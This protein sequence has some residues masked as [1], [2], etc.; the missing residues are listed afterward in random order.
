[1][2]RLHMF[3]DD[4]TYHG[5]KQDVTVQWK[6][7]CFPENITDVLETCDEKGDD[8]VSEYEFTDDKIRNTTDSER[9]V[10]L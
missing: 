7:N 9:W 10:V 1:M 6:N 2:I 4:P 8:C 3:L 5:L